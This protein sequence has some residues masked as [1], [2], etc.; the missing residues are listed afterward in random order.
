MTNNIA[1]K[2]ALLTSLLIASCATTRFKETITVK[3]TIIIPAKIQL[4]TLFQFK[5]SIVTIHDTT[6]QMTITIQKF[7]DKYIRVQGICKPKEII[8]PITKTITKTKQVIVKNSFYKYSFYLLLLFVGT[9][10][11]FSRFR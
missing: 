4:D 5:D 6:G 2:F 3:D 10:L 7:R 9:Y 1:F 11:V 8:I